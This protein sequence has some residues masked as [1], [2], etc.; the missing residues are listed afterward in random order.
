M[1]LSHVV[2]FITGAGQGLGRATAKHLVSKNARVVIA[3][4]SASHAAAVAAELGG[5]A[6]AIFAAIDVTDEQQVATSLARAVQ[7]FGKVNVVVNC[8]GIAP[9]MRTLG[10]K[11]PHSLA[12]FAKVMTINTVGT[13][14][15][16]SKAAEKMALNEPDE[17]GLRGLIVNTA[18]VAAF[19]GQIGQAA[20]AASKG[21][22]AAMTLPIARDLSSYGIRVCT[23]APGLFL[24]PMMEG[25]PEQVRTELAATVPLPKRLGR[26]HEYALLVEAIITNPMLNGETIRLDGALRMQP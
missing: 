22:V 1:P 5:D 20:Y 21:A 10:R 19:D 14:N 18:S 12:Q 16:L 11:G 3:D 24:T 17:S 25:L 8:A 7:S 4:V 9:P 26:P 15:V 6:K 13:F 23:I 2:A